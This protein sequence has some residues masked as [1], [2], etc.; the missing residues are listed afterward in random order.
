MLKKMTESY[1]EN[2]KNGTW[3]DYDK[4]INFDTVY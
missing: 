4:T 3:I 2:Q 1:W